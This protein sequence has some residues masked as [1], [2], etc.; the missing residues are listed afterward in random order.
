MAK[1]L[2]VLC[3][4]DLKNKSCLPI[5]FVEIPPLPDSKDLNVCLTENIDFT[6]LKQKKILL[7]R[8]ATKKSTYF[9]DKKKT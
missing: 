6:G 1:L 7:Y 5:I 3:C 4:T 2:Y 9:F 8:A